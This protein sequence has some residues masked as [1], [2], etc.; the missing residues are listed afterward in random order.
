MHSQFSQFSS[1][2]DF[3]CLPGSL[4]RPLC[5]Y[6]Y[7][8]LVN[9]ECVERLYSFSMAL[10]FLGFPP[11][12]FCLASCSPQPGLQSQA[13]R[14]VRVCFFQFLLSLP[15]LLTTQLGMGF[16]PQMQINP[17]PS[18]SEAAGFQS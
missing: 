5:I 10:A 4:G 18:D 17:S 12:N 3:Y 13:S 15:L 9:P 1:L 6:M 11:L 14:A 8:F 16:H 7:S 2:P